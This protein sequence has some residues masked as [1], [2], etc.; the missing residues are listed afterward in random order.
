MDPIVSRALAANLC[1]FSGRRE[2]ASFAEDFC[3]PVGEAVEATAR[4]A[5]WQGPAK[6]LEHMLSGKQRIDQTI[7]ASSGSE[8][9]FR[10]R[11][12]MPRFGTSQ[13]EFPLEVSQRHVEI[14]HILLESFG[15]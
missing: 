6:H 1:P 5:V 10:L 7:E 9:R 12:K 13:L 14:A 2:L 15:L 3:E 8:R 4:S 11:N